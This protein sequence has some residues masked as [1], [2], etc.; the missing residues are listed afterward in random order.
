MCLLEINAMISASCMQNLKGMYGSR[1]HQ[2]RYSQPDSE[3]GNTN[4]ILVY[5]TR[6]CTDLASKVLKVRTFGHS[7]AVLLRQS[8]FCTY[9]VIHIKLF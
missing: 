7:S 3:A 4:T 9:I 5:V 6:C 8:R 2:R 1:T